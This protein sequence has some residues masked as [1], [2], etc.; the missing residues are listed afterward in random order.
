MAPVVFVES[1]LMKDCSEDYAASEH[2]NKYWNAVSAPSDK[3]WPK[4]LTED[5]DELF[6]NNKLLVPENPVEV[7]IDHWHNAG[8]MHPG[9]FKMQQD[10]ECRF[11]LLLGYYAI[12]NWYCNHCALCRATKSPNHS[13]AGN[14]VYTA[15]PGGTDALHCHGC[16]CYA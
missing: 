4:V 10:L 8:L 1:V 15:I 2:W 6:L 11:E 12:W 13:T 9:R 14:A 16:V 3:E 7:L 5:G